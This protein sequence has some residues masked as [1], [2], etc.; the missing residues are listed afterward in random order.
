MDRLSKMNGIQFSL[1]HVCGPLFVIGKLKRA[2]E[3]NFTPICYY[4]CMD[5]TVYQC[6]DLYTF[7]Q[8]RLA[9][10]TNPLREALTQASKYSRY[11]FCFKQ[12]IVYKVLD[13]M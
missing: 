7:I 11:L 13:L 2:S 5:G 8:S 4:Y 9:Q 10:T 1:V 6:P 3:T 12:L